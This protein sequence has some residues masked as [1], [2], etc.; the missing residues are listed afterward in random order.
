VGLAVPVAATVGLAV[1][2]AVALG[3]PVG[4]FSSSPPQLAAM[5][6][7]ATTAKDTIARPQAWRDMR[8]RCS[9][10]MAFSSLPQF[11]SPPPEI[12]EIPAPISF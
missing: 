10:F 5:A 8:A 2:V 3:V 7:R 12:D 9:T 11:Y 6:T 4:A 1:P